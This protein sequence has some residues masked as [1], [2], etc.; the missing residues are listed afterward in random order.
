MKRERDPRIN[1][2]SLSVK[3]YLLILL[4]CNMICAAM[5]QVYASIHTDG[6]GGNHRET[7]REAIPIMLVV[8]GY[9]VFASLLLSGLV[10]LIRYY[11]IHEKITVLNDAA[12]RVAAGDYSVTIPPRRRD[13]KVDE[14]EA[15]YMDFN[16]MT[17][18]LARRAIMREGF[19]S[20]ISHEFK[21]P[22]SVINNYITILQSDTLS[23]ADQE[24]YLERVRAASAKLSDMVGNILQI[25]RMENGK[26]AVERREYDLSE[27][28]IQ[29]VLSFDPKLSEK[30]I[31]LELDC[32]EELRIVS[33]M[34]LLQ[35][36]WNNLLNNAVKF[37]PEGGTIK[38]SAA[39]EAAAVQ[40]CVEDNG[41]GIPEDELGRIFEKFYQADRSHSTAGNGLGLAMVKNI[42]SLL[43]CQIQVR[44]REGEGSEFIF[45]IPKG[46]AG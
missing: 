17:A 26:I 4:L 36:V 2:S 31:A 46:S 34:G 35:I 14:F 21:K 16:S 38:I 25:S 10:V 27:Q 7:L 5:V 19:L 41:C 29:T 20:N 40:V 3:A 32:P 23:P 30:N 6:I 22:L 8:A 43:A 33:D 15:L 24:A 11:I 9:V 42:A 13:G 18:Q 45:T 44:S 37:T 12:R 39:A 1:A 28:L